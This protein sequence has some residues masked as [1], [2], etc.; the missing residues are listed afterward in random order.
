MRI[1]IKR[2]TKTELLRETVSTDRSSR[3]DAVHKWCGTGVYL[4]FRE[5]VKNRI[6]FRSSRFDFR[7]Y[8][9]SLWVEP[10]NEGDGYY[11]A[12]DLNA[13]F[14]KEYRGCLNGYYY[15]LINERIFIGYDVG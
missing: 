15:L 13:G 7:G 1:A 3:L 14:S 11:L 6:P 8:D 9:G 10:H 12:G 5:A 2:F 4:Q